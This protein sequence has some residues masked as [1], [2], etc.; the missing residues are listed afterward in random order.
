MKLFKYLMSWSLIAARGVN[1]APIDTGLFYDEYLQAV[2]KILE[3]DDDLRLKMEMGDL[4]HLK[5]N[6]LTDIEEINELAQHLRD[7]LDELKRSEVERIRKL[8]KAQN[9]LNEGKK[10]NIKALIDDVT[11]H[12]DPENIENFSMKDLNRLIKTVAHDMENFD[13]KRHQ[14][15]KEY[16]MHKAI[17]REEKMAEMNEYEKAQFEAE[18]KMKRKRHMEHAKIPHPI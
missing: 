7:E 6:E 9:K 4:N 10:V 11:G 16:E 12:F 2:I 5:I 15:F 8:L 17:E 3:K 18:E 1:Q 14:K 13:E